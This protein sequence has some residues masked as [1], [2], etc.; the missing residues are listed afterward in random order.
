MTW[1]RKSCWSIRKTVGIFLSILIIYWWC[2]MVLKFDTKK[3]WE[4]EICSIDEVDVGIVR[5]LRYYFYPLIIACNWC[6]QLGLVSIKKINMDIALCLWSE[7]KKNC[8]QIC[9]S[10][11]LFLYKKKKKERNLDLY[12]TLL[13][14]INIA[15]AS[16]IKK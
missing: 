1:D 4:Q 12:I 14:N 9:K 5:F 8:V 7:N 2:N 16:T 15:A 13:C 10:A 11:P 6:S 3:K